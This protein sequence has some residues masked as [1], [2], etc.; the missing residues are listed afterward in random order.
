MADMTKQ[1][2]A[3]N[4]RYSFET[5]TLNPGIYFLKLSAGERSSVVKFIVSR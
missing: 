1:F 2:Q 3:G 5:S 4:N